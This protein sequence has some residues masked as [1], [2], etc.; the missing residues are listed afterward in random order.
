ML[1]KVLRIPMHFSWSM[2]RVFALMAR[3]CCRRALA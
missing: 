1:G 3:S 2:N